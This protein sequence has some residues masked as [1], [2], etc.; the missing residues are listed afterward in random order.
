MPTFREHI[1]GLESAGLL[2]RVTKPVDPE[3]E[4]ASM[5]RWMY[6]GF[7]EGDRF[8][9]RFDD[10]EGYDIPVI[11]A[12]LGASRSVYAHGLGVTP[13]DIHTHWR[14]SLA[15]R[16]APERVHSAPVHERVAIGTDASL[17]N[18][19]IPVW[20]PRKDPGPYLTTVVVT[21]NRETGVQNLAIYRCQIINED[22]IA[23]NISPHR[24]GGRDF[25][26][27][28]D[29]GEP[30]PVAIVIGAAPAVHLSSIT[31]IDY[32][33]D[34]MELAGGLLGEPLQTVETK[35]V[36]LDV[37]A[38]A[39]VVIEGEIDP[40]ERIQ[41]GPF[42]E[43]AGY[44]GHVSEKPVIDVTG[45]SRRDEPIVYSLMGQ[46]PPSEDHTIQSISNA[47]LYEKQLVD[48]EGHPTISDLAI[49]K[50]YSGITGHGI[51]QI[52]PRYP[53]EGAEVGTKLGSITQ[54]KRVTVVN[55][56]V[57]PRDPLHVAWAVNA[58]VNPKR[59]VTTLEDVYLNPAKDPAAR[60]E[61]QHESDSSKLVVDATKESIPETLPP[62]A[63]PPRDDMEDALE[64]WAAA[65]LP[66]I[67]PKQRMQL[68]LEHHP[69]PSRRE[70]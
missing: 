4:L 53:E 48:D 59:D 63:I 27:Y 47:A 26:S 9:L 43:F 6:H 30:A 31:N 16:H 2:E 20:T 22:T 60:T 51:V 10:V 14:D 13:D 57:D 46:V 33:E 50:T 44:M 54:L 45:I 55:R 25:H 21:K 32:E 37:P 65:D 24:H 64:S 35:T 58:R 28:A 39:E 70:R 12:A 52:D 18:L 7:D 40:T 19:P 29:V 67:E 49:D 11:T 61:P 38:S 41:E 68:M 62:M 36:D 69:G 17:G 42:G 66:D 23:I 5:A 56:D 3:W 15:N 1:D 8:A 34:E